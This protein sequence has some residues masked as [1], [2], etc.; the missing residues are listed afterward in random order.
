LSLAPPSSIT[1]SVMTP[2]ASPATS[3]ASLRLPVGP[4]AAVRARLNAA[5]IDGII[6]GVIVRVLVGVL[7]ASTFS[8]D[9]ILL[10]FAGQFLY[11]F[12]MEVGTGQ[13]LGKRCM[14]VRVV[15]LDGSV[16]TM[17]MCAIRNALRFVDALPLC[18]ASGLL[19]L[20]RTGRS[21]RQR[22]GDV[23]A[24]T[25]VAVGGGGKQLTTPRWL[26]PLCAVT[27]TLV[28]VAWIVVALH[29]GARSG[30]PS[31]AVAAG[32][33]GDNSQAPS[34]GTWE[35]MGTVT[36][37]QGDAGNL[38][39]Q[40]MPRLWEIV[41]TCGAGSCASSL[42][43]QVAG[44]PPLTAVLKHEGDGWHAT[45]PNRI[46]TC[47]QGDGQTIRG[48]LESTWVLQF[49]AGGT[50]AAAHETNLYTPGCGWGTDTV[51][52]TA[53]LSPTPPQQDPAS[54]G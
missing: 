33:A 6:I 8:G 52:W 39:G 2:V 49:T 26:L 54:S 50:V 43:R 5:I 34:S 37:A 23:V 44:E 3:G 9:G 45:F 17:R 27:A 24:G 15:A 30:P 29:A 1:G 36:S 20:I 13:T 14:N 12:I 41:R 47:T 35:A 22:I 19:S 4:D 18:Y 42:T 16:A 10:I 7:S 25:T 21:R 51:N 53:K 31:Q 38:P 46:Y 28:S 40:E 11:F 32:F 48:V